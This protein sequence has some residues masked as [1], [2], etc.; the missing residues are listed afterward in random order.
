MHWYTSLWSTNLCT[1][2]FF[3]NFALRIRNLDRAVYM[4]K[5]FIYGTSVDG[6]NFTDRVK[7]TK[8]L[9][10]DFENGLNTILISPRRM[11]KTSLVNR[12]KSNISRDDI[13]IVTMDIYDCRS[14]YDFLNR[15]AASILKATAG[16]MDKV[17]STVKEFLA[18]IVPTIKYSLDPAQ[19]FSLSLGITPEIYNPEEI[20]NL[21]EVIAQSKGVHIIVCIDEFQQVG[22][23][24]DSLNVQKRMR[25]V[26]QHHHNTSYCMYGSKKHL[27]IKI[28]QNK[29]MPF[30]KFGETLFL[31][32]IPD[33]DWVPFIIERFNSG[34][35]IISEEFAQR[36]CRTVD[37]YSSYV[38]ELS[39]DVY[40][41]TDDVVT[42]ESFNEGIKD[43]LRQNSALFQTRIETLTSYQ[44]NLL[45][46]LCDGVH[47]DFGSM[48]I[49]DKYRLGTKSNI[50]RLK[51]SLTDKELI[52]T[53]KGMTTLADPVF[54]LWFKTEY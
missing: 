1:N 8:R 21:P 19:E 40:A 53:E 29:R 48:R 20:L 4:K 2:A 37:G 17:I 51:N 38:Q 26:W 45:H 44:M 52:E 14:E 31:E 6:D 39:W 12:V 33:E 10:L 41:E 23:F 25:G 43:L 11:G 49:I 3:Y 54:E 5:P 13:M 42:E 24:P 36:I 15:F 46:A 22:E 30:Y 7:D 18:R 16:K 50:T 27:M 34:G 28:F 32:K 9:T 35:K 47:S